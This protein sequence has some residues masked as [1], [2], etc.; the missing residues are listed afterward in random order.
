MILLFFMLVQTILQV[1]AN[2]GPQCCLQTRWSAYIWFLVPRND[3]ILIYVLLIRITRGVN[4]FYKLTA[5][6]AKVNKLK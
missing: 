1:T 4:V 2:S 5:G 6:S 3:V